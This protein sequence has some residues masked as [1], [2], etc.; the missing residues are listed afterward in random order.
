M[1]FKNT[2]SLN[3]RN[4][5]RAGAAAG[6]SSLAMP[7]V[8][9]AQSEKTVKIG[10]IDPRTGTYA[11]LGGNQIRGAT[12]AVDEINKKGGILGRP[13]QLLVEDSQGLPGPAVSKAQ[14]LVNQDKVNFLMGSVSSAVSGS[15]S[16]FANQHDLV[17]VDSGG[18]AD[19]ITGKKCTWNT[20]RTCSTTWMLTAG[21]FE[22]LFKKFGKKW[23]FITPDYAFGHALYTDY[24]AQLTKAGGTALGNALAPL[25]TTDFSSYLIQ[26]RAAKPDVLICLQAG[27]DLVNLLKQTVQFGMNTQ[28][29]VAGAMQEME[30]LEALPP[31]ALLG[32]WTF[33]WYW[34]QP[35]VPH[36]AD[37]VKAYKSRYN[38]KVPTARSWFG[39]ATAHALALAANQAK[40]LDALKVVR[41]L[42][43]LELPPEVALQPGKC[44]YRAQ[45]HQM[46]AN[47]FP[48]Y[49]PKDA[50][51]PNLFD[52][53]QT[54]PGG[55]IAKS[56]EEAGCKMA[57]PS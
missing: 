14:K 30:V 47:M 42:E 27:D 44:Y 13:V 40:S 55:D 11:A 12:M 3:R 18:H 46:I 39:Y 4:L 45:D 21:D 25:G 15:L 20:F 22:P 56:P 31:A 51:Y 17:F 35:N 6:V 28:M 2:A 48:G 52:V 43:G 26:A 32:W 1:V 10:N 7:E 54:I 8:S 9:W 41:A 29:T 53:S 57:Y 37:F 36:V 38:N 23:F 33:E 16:Q 19:A 5:L 49:V 24:V 34:N 50:S